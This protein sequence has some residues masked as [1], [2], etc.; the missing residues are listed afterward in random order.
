MLHYT[1]KNDRNFIPGRLAVSKPIIGT[2]GRQTQN[3]YCPGQKGTYGEPS[4]RYTYRFCFPCRVRSGFQTLCCL[5]YRLVCDDNGRFALWTGLG[6]FRFIF[7]FLPVPPVRPPPPFE[8][9]NHAFN[10]RE[11]RD[12]SVTRKTI[13]I[14][15]NRPSV[16]R[17]RTAVKLSQV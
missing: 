15:N 14:I 1:N 11:R 8:L 2:P 16:R 9:L 10:K 12:S 17:N 4:I 5:S 13:I 3:R 6:G 7:R